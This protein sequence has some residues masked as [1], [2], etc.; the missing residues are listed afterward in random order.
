M[1][2]SAV[3]PPH[4]T[5][6]ELLSFLQEAGSYPHH[7]AG[8][9]ILQT[10]SAIVAI[11]SPFVY[12]VRKPVNFGFLDFSTLEKRLHFAQREIELN[13][14]LCHEVH[15]EIV[16]ISLTND[17]LKFG[18]GERVV[19]YAVK[20]RELDERWFMKPMLRGGRVHEAELDRVVALLK[21]FYE[22]PVPPSVLEWGRVERLKI[23]TDENF[24]QAHAFIGQ[25]LSPAAFGAIRQ[26]TDGYYQFH[27]GLFEERI[28]Q[29]RIVDGHGDLHLEHI[30]L[31]PDRVT[32]FDCIEF[33]DRFRFLD[34]AND[35]AFLA[36]DLDFENR[37]DLSRQFVRR[38]AEALGDEG[39]FRLI[40]FYKCYR[41]FVRGKVE[42]MQAR[43]PEVAPREREQCAEWARRYFRLA[44]RYAVAGSTPTVIVTMGRPGSGKSVLAQGISTE[45][46][47]PVSSSDQV[48]KLIAGLPLTRRP[49]AKIRAQL[50]SNAMSRRTYSALLDIALRETGMGRCVV[51][52][53]TFS[54]ASLRHEWRQRL[55]E[56]GIHLRF[57]EAFAPDEVLC[58]RLKFRDGKTDVISDARVED[59]KKLSEAYSPPIELRP[60]ELVRVET[61]NSQT[62]SLT[63][64]LIALARNQTR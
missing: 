15:L 50:Y 14:R 32:V 4:V 56:A 21:P 55:G 40:D 22:R 63:Q 59:F 24:Q 61:T 60:N 23:N 35:I 20:M 48:R 31:A 57:V 62:K 46:A 52:D 29:R 13:R 54:Q 36:M 26:Y 17:H 6:E 49:D 11:A 38:M 19:D 5:P 51:I 41:A 30:H 43:E 25:T 42:S 47:C 3:S 33:N 37:T 16:P 34:V 44:L 39:I 1:S 64:A 58:E 45:L 8:V 27:A 9:R 7:P 18:E 2:P 10:H 53:A 12:K 28:R